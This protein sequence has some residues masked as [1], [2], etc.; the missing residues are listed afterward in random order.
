MKYGYFDNDNCE[1]V[2]I[3][4]DVFVFWINYFGI[5][6]FCMVILYNVGGYFFYYLFE[7]NCVIKFC[8]NFI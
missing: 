7:Y 3:C 1:Y 8:L 2:I 4:F 6:K 5:E